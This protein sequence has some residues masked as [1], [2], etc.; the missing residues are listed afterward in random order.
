M[1]YFFRC[2]TSAKLQKHGNRGSKVR[3]KRLYH[4]NIADEFLKATKQILL[5]LG[6][7]ITEAQQENSMGLDLFEHVLS[8]QQLAQNERGLVLEVESLGLLE[9]LL[10]HV[11]VGKSA[12][13]LLLLLHELIEQVGAL[14]RA[15]VERRRPGG[16]LVLQL[17]QA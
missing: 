10:L 5:S 7:L 8:E 2:C 15:A 9:Q 3:Q 17:L 16:E 13:R 14:L 4:V 11:D 1:Q 12:R 6:I